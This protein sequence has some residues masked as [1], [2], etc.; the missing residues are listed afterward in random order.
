VVSSAFSFDSEK[1]SDGE[2]DQMVHESGGTIHFLPRRNIECYHIHPSAIATFIVSHDSGLAGTVTPE[3]VSQTL[4]ELASA[5]QYRTGN[6]SG[7]LYDETWLALVDGA[8]LI[9][10]ACTIIT[11]ARVVFHKNGD[12]L[13]LIQILQNEQPK[14]LDALAAYTKSLVEAAA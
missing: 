3:A 11:D 8:K 10:E 7:N 1:L 4:V 9:T 5:T 6:W 13:K 2:K 12:T 14:A